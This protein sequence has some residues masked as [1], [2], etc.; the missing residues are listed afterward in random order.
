MDQQVQKCTYTCQG[1]EAKH[2]TFLWLSHFFY[3]LECGNQHTGFLFEP[4]VHQDPILTRLAGGG[5]TP[6]LNSSL[7]NMFYSATTIILNNEVKLKYQN[8]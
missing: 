1:L 8:T 6:Q 3:E 4:F 2:F 5:E 7:E